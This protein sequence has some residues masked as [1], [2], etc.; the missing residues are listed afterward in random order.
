M[1]LGDVYKRQTS[2]SDFNNRYVVYNYGT[3]NNPLPMGNWYTGVN[4]NSIRTTW[5][6]SLVY[7][8]PYATAYNSSNTGTFPAI[9]GETGLGQSV[10]FEHETGTDQVNPDGSV[11]TLTSFVQSYDFSLQTDQGAAEYFLAMRRF[12][13]NFKILQGNASV[14]ISVADYPADPNTTST[15]SPFTVDSTTTKVDTR[16]RGR[17][18]ALKI[19]NTG[20]SES[21]R[22]GTFQADL[23]PDGRR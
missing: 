11:T 14:T 2:G 20:V 23:Q 9:I 4:T 15:L 18:A 5:I 17:Y 19:E 22:F 16:A 3:V 7:P 13:P 21:W 8:K 6:D 10:L 12:L 1:G